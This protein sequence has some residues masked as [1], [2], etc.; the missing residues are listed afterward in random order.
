[1]I[2]RRALTTILGSAVLTLL[3]QPGFTAD[4]AKAADAAKPAGPNRIFQASEVSS[5]GS[6]TIGGKAVA[7]Q[8]VAGTL[9]VHGPGWD[10]VAWREQAAVPNPDK[11][12]EGR[13]P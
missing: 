2:G 9:V 8:A 5:S 3:A 13:P 1:M 11:D 4:D 10:D 7:Y 12:K 6:V